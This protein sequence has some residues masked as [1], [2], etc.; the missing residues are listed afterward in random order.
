MRATE[1]QRRRIGSGLLAACCAL[2]TSGEAAAEWTALISAHPTT[3]AAEVRIG[4]DTL[5]AD[6]RWQDDRGRPGENISLVERRLS[7]AAWTDLRRGFR[8]GLRLPLVQRS[9]DRT[10][11]GSSDAERFGI[12]DGEIAVGWLSRP[13]AAAGRGTLELRWKAPSGSADASWGDGTLQEPALAPLGTGGHDIDLWGGWQRSWRAVSLTAAAGLRLRTPSRATWLWNGVLLGGTTPNDRLLAQAEFSWQ[14]AEALRVGGG[15][16]AFHELVRGGP[17][18]QNT[19]HA[20]T[21][22]LDVE[23]GGGPWAGALGAE[24]PVVGRN[25]PD[26]P[27]FGLSEREPL[28]GVRVGGSLI[29]RFAGDDR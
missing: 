3:A 5:H 18:A 17:G 20:T 12:G 7:L 1:V 25:W 26:A 2:A 16:E 14:A 6:G 27:P 15:L 22:R 10:D 29:W 19:S 11:G 13:G 28:V 9:L 21:A 24:L 23:V 8:A 4:L